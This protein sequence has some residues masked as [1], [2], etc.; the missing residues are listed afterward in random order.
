MLLEIAL[1]I[2]A[3]LIGSVATAVLTCRLLGL[4][5]PRTVGSGNPGATN[6]LRMGGKK[7]AIITLLGDMLKGLIPVLAAQALGFADAWLGAVA[8]AAFVGHL[9]PVF[10]G[11]KGG[12]GVATALGVLLGLSWGVGAL[13]LVTW[14]AVAAISRISSLS[15]LVAALLAP[16]YTAWLT[17]SPWLIAT[18][19]AMTVLIYWRHR[20]NIRNLLAGTEGRIGARKRNPDEAA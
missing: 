19:V 12:K 2:G 6:V 9:F 17:G 18:T 10:F 1:V 7:A 20:S 4:P 5:D 14:L 15:A 11:F 8:L 3:Y 13:V 16:A